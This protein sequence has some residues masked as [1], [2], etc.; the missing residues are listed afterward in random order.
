MDPIEQRLEHG[1]K[2]ARTTVNILSVSRSSGDLTYKTLKP[3]H[4]KKARLIINTTPLGMYP[5][6]ESCPDI[7]YDYISDSH[8]LFDLVYNPQ[9]TLFLKNSARLNRGRVS[10]FMVAILVYVGLIIQSGYPDQ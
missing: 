6:I 9:K 4:I 10:I 1:N 3:E 8:Y 2:K 5:E 7:P